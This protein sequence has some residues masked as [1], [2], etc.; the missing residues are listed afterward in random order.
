M[1]VP[2][3]LL[4]STNFST[5]PFFAEAFFTAFRAFESSFRDGVHSQYKIFHGR[6]ELVS[7]SGTFVNARVYR[8]SATYADPER[9]DDGGKNDTADAQAERRG[10]QPR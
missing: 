8:Q 4:F 1:N 7:A 9:N 6:H 5:Q 3:L 2:R 10:K